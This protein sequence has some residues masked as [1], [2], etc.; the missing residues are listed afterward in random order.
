MSRYSGQKKKW[1]IRNT[2]PFRD[3]INSIREM[4]RVDS[5]IASLLCFNELHSF[6]DIKNFFNPDIQLLHDPVLMSDMEKAA[7]RIVSAV[8]SEEKILVYGDYDV[9]GTT[10]VALLYSFL[11]T[12]TANVGYYIPDRYSEGYGLSFTGVNFAADN[13]YTLL[14]TLDCGIKSHEKIEYARKKGLDVIVCDHHLPGDELPPAYAILNPK[15]PGCSYPYKELTGCGIGFKLVQYLSRMLERDNLWEEYLDLVAL[16]I[17]ADLVPITG[18]NRVLTYLGLERINKSPRPAI[19]ALNR[20]TGRESE[21]DIHK[22]VFFLGPRINSAGRIKHGKLAVDFLLSD[23]DEEADMLAQQ[24]DKLNLERKSLDAKVTHDAL[25]QIESMGNVDRKKAIV[26]SGENWSKGVIGIVASRIIDKYYRP[27]IVFCRNEDCWIGSGRSIPGF[28]LHEAIEHCVDYVEQFGGHTFAA[29]L[30]VKDEMLDSFKEK[31]ENYAASVLSDEQLI[32]T[33]DI[34]AELPL[35]GIRDDFLNVL[36]RF[37]PFG[38]GNMNP[39]FCARG[40]ID[41]GWC[42]IVGENSLRMELYHRNY[43]QYRFPAIGFHLGDYFPILHRRQPVDIAYKIV[44]RKNG[45]KLIP[46]L[47][48]EDIIVS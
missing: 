40:V 41:T 20:L 1:N 28:D 22:I 18:E 25:E 43:P 39:V 5:V 21:Y 12:L 24:I 23:D 11:K 31:F 34:S 44:F 32:P 45:E 42:K 16:S 27:A 4:C 38:P 15:K 3:K 19:S 29:G 35:F 2:E 47:E 13:G 36:A 8:E 37:A 33:L 46:S 14:I 7:D 6:E 17:G 10:A 9:D 26:V 48:V 30:T